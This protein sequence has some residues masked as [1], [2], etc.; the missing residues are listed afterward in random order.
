MFLFLSFNFQIKD[1][2]SNDIPTKDFSFINRVLCISDLFDEE[3][4]TKNTGRSFDSSGVHLTN[5]KKH[6]VNSCHYALYCYDEY[7][8]TGNDRLK[9]AFINQVNFLRD[10]TFYNVVDGDM[11]G[12]PYNTS[13]H[14]LKAPWYSALAQS[15]A[16][17]VLIRY[18]ELTNDDSILPLVHMVMK[19]MLSPQKQGS[20]TLSIT[21]EGNVW[22]EEYPNSTQ[23]RQ[24][25][26][27]FMFTILALHDYS[28]LFPH[29]KSA[30]LAY[31][32]AIQT[33]NEAFQF[34]N[35][36]SWLMYNR[37]DKRLVANGYM[38]WQVL[39][40]K[41]L[42]ETTKDI[43]FKNISMLISTYCYNKNYE[44]PGSKLE[45]YNFSVPLELTDN[46]IISIKPTVNA[47]KLPV[48]I[49][50]VKSNFS[51]VENDYSKMYDANLNTFV[52]LKY[53]D[54]F[55]G[56]ASIIFNFKKGI[57]ASK[58][59]LKYIGLD[60]VAKP[61]IILKYKS[62][63][64]SSEWKKLKYTSSVLDSKTMVYDFDE[65]TIANLEVIF[66]QL[67]TGGLI[68][69]SNVDLSILTKNE[70]SDYWHYITPVYRGY[71]KKVE[72][73]IKYQS[74]KD[75][76]VFY[77]TG[78]DEKSLGKDKWNPLNA[79]RK[80]PAS[81]EKEQELYWQ[82]LIVS[83]LSGQQSKISKVEFVSQ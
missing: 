49:K 82:F 75:V 76:L 67:K 53:T 50:D 38:K 73:D 24:V 54:A 30:E 51:I 78:V 44:S 17:C 31:N 57:S 13:F 25:L 19:F 9:K 69:L 45:K 65:K 4:W 39:E 64:N 60:S 3:Q 58:F 66:P 10:S 43:Y 63:I 7:K 80:F 83:E 41:M 40:A 27:G 29:N 52:E 35:T 1:E 74:M 22:Y 23:E 32:D 34:Y 11:V 77:K 42:Y 5:G 6:P 70:K 14:D 71:S 68:K 18:Y 72:F 46:K 79:F 47:Y 2:P 81:F 61:E 20:G 36:G 62:D 26:N 16:I 56:S 21:P 59:S 37:G 8:R 48:E 15:E 55:E 12:Y 33:L 28:K